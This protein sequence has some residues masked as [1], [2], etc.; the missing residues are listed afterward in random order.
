MF[1]ATCSEAPPAQGGEMVATLSDS[2]AAGLG[3]PQDRPRDL[4]L[5]FTVA[6][7][8]NLCPSDTSTPLMRRGKHKRRFQGL[9]RSPV[10]LW[11][12]LQSGARKLVPS[13][14][15]VPALSPVYDD[16][17]EARL[18]N[19]VTE[20]SFRPS[21]INATPCY[22]LPA[23]SH[24]LLLPAAPDFGATDLRRVGSCLGRGA[25]GPW[26]CASE[27]GRKIRGECRDAH[28]RNRVVIVA[29]AA[30]CRCG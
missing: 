13:F 18:S 1:R 17:S 23:S 11:V 24:S 27:T 14:S 10:E 9:E 7:G 8:N 25:G 6:I 3:P 20:L 19:S 21:C 26:L 22:Q 30:L 16:Y 29:S 2:P 4:E 28:P 12:Q 5:R 15:R